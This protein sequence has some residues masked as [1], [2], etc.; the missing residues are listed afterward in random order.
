MGLDRTG[1]RPARRTSRA[2]S[3]SSAGRC[4]LR[5]RTSSCSS[6][7]RSSTPTTRACRSGGI[8]ILLALWSASGGMAALITGIH[9]A[10]ERDEPKGFVVKKGK[11][12]LLTLG[13]IVFIGIVIFLV[14]AVPPLL[15][16]S[17]SEMPGAS[18]SM[19]CAADP[20]GA[21]RWHRVALP[22]LGEGQPARPARLP[23]PEH[24]ARDGGLA[25]R[26]GPVRGLHGEL[27]EL[28]GAGIRTRMPVRAGDF[29]CRWASTAEYRQVRETARQS[30]FS[31]L[32]PQASSAEYGGVQGPPR[33]PARPPN[34]GRTRSSGSGSESGS[35]CPVALA[36][37]WLLPSSY[38]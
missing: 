24:G 9:V 23:H 8:A 17:G 33:D 16:D 19:S 10:R 30:R 11:A 26:V 13:A 2:R 31:G 4:R 21:R 12:L 1:S 15:D 36:A 5:S 20:R 27:R 6:S 7:R 34:S 37:R 22:L 35:G 38:R 28:A 25:G 32:R 29:K 3:R 18:R 14:A